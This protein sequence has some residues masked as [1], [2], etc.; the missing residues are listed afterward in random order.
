MGLAPDR[1]PARAQ[2]RLALAVQLLDGVVVRLAHPAGR[3]APRDA[4]DSERGEALGRV[5]ELFPDHAAPPVE[6]EFAVLAV[7]VVVVPGGGAEG[8]V[9]VGLCHLWNKG[10]WG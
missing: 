4:R 6:A 10:E 3:V 2:V 7:D 5:V 1:R 9:A 8:V